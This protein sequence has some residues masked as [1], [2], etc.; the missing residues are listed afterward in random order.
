M[1]IYRH[2]T[3][4]QIIPHFLYLDINTHRWKWVPEAATITNNSAQGTTPAGR[5]GASTGET[6]TSDH[7]GWDVD[8]DGCGGWSNGTVAGGSNPEIVR[9]SGSRSGGGKGDESAI[10]ARWGRRCSAIL[11]LRTKRRSRKIRFI[12]YRR[13]DNMFGLERFDESLFTCERGMTRNECTGYTNQW[14]RCSI[15]ESFDLSLLPLNLTD[16]FPTCRSPSVI[17]NHSIKVLI[18]QRILLF[19]IAREGLYRR[20]GFDVRS[21]FRFWLVNCELFGTDLLTTGIICQTSLTS[22]V[23]GIGRCRLGTP[24]YAG[25]C[26]ATS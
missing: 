13:F 22:T 10:R 14:F 26:D 6:A 7:G 25:G 16:S 17:H 11:C 1:G 5:V 3:S 23:S 24:S 21:L 9:R 20:C 18:C 15:G 8:R 2:F 19:G 12:F 4:A